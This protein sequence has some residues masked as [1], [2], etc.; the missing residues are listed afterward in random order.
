[1]P[2]GGRY[3]TVNVAMWGDPGFRALSLGAKL[4]YLA[5]STGASS[6]FCGLGR[7]YVEEL[8]AE[9]GLTKAELETAFG[10]LE[11]RPTPRHSFVVRDR[12]HGLFWLRNSLR[13]DPTRENDPQIRNETHRKGIYTIL[14]ELPKDSRV[15]RMFRRTY[16]FP[17]R[18]PSKGPRGGQGSPPEVPT[19]ESDYRQ[20]TSDT[21]A[22]VSNLQSAQDELHRLQEEYMA[23]DK[24]L[25]R[26]AA[27]HMALRELER[28][29]KERRDANE[30]R[31]GGGEGGPPKAIADL[32]S[33][34]LPRADVA[35]EPQS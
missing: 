26:G 7:Y 29:A 27:E 33:E 35:D 2:R 3:R 30:R 15:V 18:T 11:K 24:N 19:T 6:A 28:R 34:A 1:M 32:A 23:A 5:L 8:I 14:G 10:E 22:K 25:S 16:H 20:P 21:R 13:D 4:L 9:T 17:S 12:W 31:N